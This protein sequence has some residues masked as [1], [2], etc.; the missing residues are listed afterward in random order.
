MSLSEYY[1]GVAYDEYTAELTQVAT[2]VRVCRE[3]F[4]IMSE[5]HL[6]QEM[7]YR[8]TA[9]VISEKANPVR[10]RHPESWRDGLKEWM[11]HTI[12][13]DAPK[14]LRKLVKVRYVEHVIEAKAFYP[15]WTLN[16][17]EAGKRVVKIAVLR[18]PLVRYGG[19]P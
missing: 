6:R 9:Y 10:I 12:L 8:L 18:S 17:P 5:N 1:L 7:E 2:Q 15:Y 11:L 3:E 16:F 13:E 19:Q 14:W 4:E